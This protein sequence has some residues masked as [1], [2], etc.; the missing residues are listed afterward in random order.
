MGEKIEI[1][2]I[3]PG[4]AVVLNVAI[5]GGARSFCRAIGSLMTSETDPI[6]IV[7]NCPKVANLEG[8]SNSLTQLSLTS[9]SDFS[10]DGSVGE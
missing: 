4:E 2:G 5:L 10:H 8:E 9:P 1:N 7:R 6:L 3:V